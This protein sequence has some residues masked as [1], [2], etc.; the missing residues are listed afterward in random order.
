MDFVLWIH[1]DVVGNNDYDFL[2][3]TEKIYRGGSEPIYNGV[4]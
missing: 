2:T 4:L 1:A 3:S